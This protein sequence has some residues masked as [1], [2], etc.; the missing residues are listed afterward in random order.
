VQ[1]ASPE[2]QGGSAPRSP[3]QVRA[4]LPHVGW[5]SHAPDD[6]L[7]TLLR[8]GYFEAEEQAFVWRY[9]RPGD[10]VLDCGAHVGLY[11]VLAARATGGDVHVVSVEPN[12][13]TAGL[14]ELNLARSGARDARVVRSAIW[15]EP[16]SVRF[17]EEIA[18]RSAWARVAVDGSEGTIEVPATTVDRLVELSG[19]PGIALVKLDVEGVEPEA[20]EGAAASLAGRAC[21]V[22][23]IE[24]TEENLRRRGS[25]TE[26]LAAVVAAHGLSL[27]E[28][29]PDGEQLV[30]FRPEGPIWFKNL[31]ATPDVDAVNARLASAPAENVEIA[32]DVLARGRACRRFKEL[33]ELD[34][35]RAVAASH[36]QW[37]RSAEALLAKERES[38][39]A[40][41]RRIEELGRVRVSPPAPVGRLE[42]DVCVCTHDPRPDVLD[43]TLRAIARQTVATGGVLI[44]DNASTPPLGPEVLAPLREAGIPARISREERRGVANA[45]RHAIEETQGDWILFVD[46]DNELDPG[47]IEEGLRFIA[48]HPDVGCFGGKLL[49]AEGV[50]APRWARPFLPYLAIKDAGEGVITGTGERWGPWEPPTAGAFVRRDLLEAY[51]SRVAQD[52][53]ILALGR[54]G[55]D[56]LGSC[57]DSLIARQ[58]YGLGLLNAYDP[59]LSLRHHVDPS[60][61]R[62]G[63][64]FRLMRGYG[65]SHVLLEDLLRREGERPG[66][67]AEYGNTRRF[68]RKVLREFDAAR[69]RSLAYGLGIVAYHLGLR[70]AYLELELERR[71]G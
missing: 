55:R 54:N 51:R 4:F 37:A 58:A 46:D 57:E 25:S 49:L 17:F 44:V 50:R 30:P 16:G 53:R 59:R 64:L 66:V 24:F 43:T 41:Q 63:Y 26:R 61:F 33:E 5:I 39:A 71:D 69:K 11:S 12:E 32:R 36:E 8:Q 9:L 10:W 21:A 28:L 3:E 1:H 20:L 6:G 13:R 67:P 29:S 62:L 56:G 65:R 27:H 23:M 2:P 15:K 18:E 19:A 14:L 70:R 60:R 7:V 31:F 40:L 38:S 45:R 47:F 48:Q 42:I 52:P 35:L 22:W 34:T 68:V